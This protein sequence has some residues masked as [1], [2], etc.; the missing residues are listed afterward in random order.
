VRGDDWNGVLAGTAVLVPYSFATR[1][2][3]SYGVPGQSGFDGYN[4]E[5]LDATQRAHIR[6]ALNHWEQVAGLVFVEV[7]DPA[8]L[9]FGGIRF[10]MEGLDAAISGLAA[11]SFDPYGS[12]VI[13][14][15]VHWGETTF[16]P[17]TRVFRTALHEIGHAIGLKHPHDG[18]PI[19]GES[20]D[21]GNN[22]IMSYNFEGKYANFSRLGPIDIA[23]AQHIYGT[24]EAEAL[25]AIRW[26][27]G[28]GGSLTTVGNDQANNIVNFDNRGVVF[29]GGGNDYIVVRGGNDDVAP[30]AGHDVVFGGTGM[31]TLVTGALR[32]QAVVEVGPDQGTVALP[33]GTDTY[34]QVETLRFADG[35]L[36]LHANGAAGQAYR[37]YGA[38][39]GRTPDQI[40][41]GHWTNALETGAISLANAA[42]DFVGSAEFASRYGAPDAAG[43]VSL[44]YQN[45]L[46][47]TADAGGLK[48]WTDM[49]EK[50]GVSR[51]GVL[52]GFSGVR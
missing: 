8:E 36:H 52:L 50:F 10:M 40:G 12:N 37:L 19:L 7:P 48:Y 3:S 29:A 5:P 26:F 11:T 42:A 51:A 30:G 38:A 22:T 14:N 4:A 43:F 25:A 21:N 39:L 16:A 35:N 6:E 15:R 1:G 13:F 44:L 45:V 41:L 34:Y 9:T 17:G 46:G 2:S 20:E 31:D 23:A 28:P 49:M 24:N 18:T 27:H 47:R 33:D 32:R